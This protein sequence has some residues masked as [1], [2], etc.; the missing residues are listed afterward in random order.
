MPSP[1][2]LQLAGLAFIIILALLYSWTM[3][4]SP[5]EDSFPSVSVSLP[6]DI[7]EHVKPPPSNA[8]IPHDLDTPPE[9]E[10]P[11]DT[12]IPKDTPAVEDDANEEKSRPEF[13]GTVD[14]L[15]PRVVLTQGTF[16]GTDLKGTYNQVLEQFLGIPYGLST[17]GKRRFKPP[18]EVKN[19]T[20]IY[21]ASQWGTRCPAGEED[22]VPQGEDC[23]NVN[24]WRPKA[25]AL[26]KKLPVVIHLHGGAFNF[27]TGSNRDIASLVGWS[28]EPM[29]GVS[30]NYRLGALGF[31]PFLPLNSGEADENPLNLGLRDQALLFDWVQQ[32]IAAFGGDPEQVTIMGI[33]AGA[34]SVC[35]SWFC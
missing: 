16:I 31:L 2:R 24:I 15:R 33:S 13:S 18:V 12:E 35:L 9:T 8:T 20:G 29:I 25:L 22:N 19:S 6:N 21:D 5:E 26:E 3:F 27:G 17:A 32:N 11:Q 1:K 34:H 28:M 14:P 23:L 10:I 7:A 30:F 4:S